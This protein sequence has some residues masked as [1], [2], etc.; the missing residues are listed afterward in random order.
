MTDGTTPTAYRIS[1]TDTAQAESLAKYAYEKL[2]KRRA[3][4]LY[5]ANDFGTGLMNDFATAFEELGGGSCRF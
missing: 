1:L 3:A 4:I 5:T 2:G